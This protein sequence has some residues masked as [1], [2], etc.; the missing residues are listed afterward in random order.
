MYFFVPVLTPRASK[1]TG[2]IFKVTV[3]EAWHP[4]GKINKQDVKSISVFIKILLL[5]VLKSV[6]EIKRVKRWLKYFTRGN[7]EV[8]LEMFDTLLNVL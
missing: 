7:T 3:P 1:N 8:I 5:I 2:G 6:C 4:C